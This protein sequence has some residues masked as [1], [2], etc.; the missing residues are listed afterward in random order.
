VIIS[1]LIKLRLQILTICADPNEGSSDANNSPGLTTGGAGLR[2]YSDGD[3]R[4]EAGLALD[5]TFTSTAS[6]LTG[7][8]K[9]LE[10]KQGRSSTTAALGPYIRIAKKS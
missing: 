4:N 6:V 9:H 2:V 10:E 3:L 7:L 5:N 1:M 8:V